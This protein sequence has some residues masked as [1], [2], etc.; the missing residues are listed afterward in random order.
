MNEYFN[1]FTRRVYRDSLLYVVIDTLRHHFGVS[2]CS[3]E[4]PSIENA[5]VVP[6][7]AEANQ[8]ND[9]VMMTDE[10]LSEQEH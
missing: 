8:G 9:G 7:T 3:A 6:P 10:R 4:S 1:S 5:V 2:S